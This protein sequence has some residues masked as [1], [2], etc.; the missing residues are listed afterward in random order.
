MRLHGIGD[1]EAANAYLPEYLAEHNRRFA[2]PAR[3]ARDAHRP[4]AH[5]RAELE[6]IFSLQHERQV[7]PNREF[8][9]QGPSAMPWPDAAW[10]CA[11]R[12]SAG[13]TKSCWVPA[14]PTPRKSWRKARNNGLDP[15]LQ[16][17]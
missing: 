13:N 15:L 4:V 12:S 1:I 17:A 8:Q 10:W 5:N 6:V 9:Y 7:S 11:K 3:E 14:P 16:W 2:K